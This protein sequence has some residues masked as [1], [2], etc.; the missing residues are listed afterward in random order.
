MKLKNNASYSQEER[1]KIISDLQNFL[2][3][4]RTN[5]I[6]FGSRLLK[7]FTVSGFKWNATDE[8]LFVELDGYIL[9]PHSNHYWVNRNELESFLKGNN[10]IGTKLMIDSVYQEKDY[11]I[12][13]VNM[14]K[15]GFK[16]SII[17]DAE[18]LKGI[19]I[20]H[21]SKLYKSYDV[22]VKLVEDLEIE[23][24]VR[25]FA[26]EPISAESFINKN[27]VFH[28]KKISLKSGIIFED[29][30]SQEEVIKKSDALEAI[31]MERKTVSNELRAWYLLNMADKVDEQFSKAFLQKLK[32]IL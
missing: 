21:D 10:P 20:I 9:N 17:Q 4:K 12:F 18:K 3:Y 2:N 23:K 22:Q 5:S 14:I 27:T 32:E 16:K 1:K 24:V 31:R 26:F 13:D 19:N 15:N 25:V 8:S 11:V 30:D 7:D 29:S 6:D 28:S